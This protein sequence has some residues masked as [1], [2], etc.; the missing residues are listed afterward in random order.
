MADDKQEYASPAKAI[1]I[2][3]YWL[4]TKLPT[5]NVSAAFVVEVLLRYYAVELDFEWDPSRKGD[6]I[7]LS[8]DNKKMAKRVTG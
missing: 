4:R 8:D 2:C 3:S 7:A 1:I 6:L 5:V